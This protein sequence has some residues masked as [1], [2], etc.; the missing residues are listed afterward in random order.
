MG[1]ATA[2]INGKTVAEANAWETVEGNIYVS[3]LTTTLQDLKSHPFQFPPD[4]ILDRSIF[5]D[6]KTT[7]TCPWKG[8]ASYSDITVDGHTV[9]D[10][11]WYYP[12]PKD[13]AKNIRD[14]IAFC[15]FLNCAVVLS[16]LITFLDKSKVQV[17]ST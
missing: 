9:Q 14:H 10:A 13:G 4:S 3:V 2:K 1:V 5:S 11:A 15:E 17:T 12:Q 16:G 7:T 8:K 6:S